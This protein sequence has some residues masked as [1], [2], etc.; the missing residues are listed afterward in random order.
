MDDL[1]S[2]AAV[3]LMLVLSVVLMVPAAAGVV[4]FFLDEIAAAVEA[5]TIRS[6]RR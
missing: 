1:L 3:G 2:W 6:C 4:G 5:R